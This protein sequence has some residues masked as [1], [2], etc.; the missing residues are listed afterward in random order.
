MTAERGAE[1]TPDRP[2]EEEPLVR[3]ERWMGGPDEVVPGFEELAEQVR[4]YG[5]LDP[6]ATIAG[7]SEASR[8][9][10]GALVRYVLARWSSGGSE[11]LLELG[12]SG[13]DH[14]VRL[15]EEAEAVGTD[16]ARLEAYRAVRDVVGW[17]RAGT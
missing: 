17:L 9:P 11:G 13:V 16:E 4:E 10:V 3:L 6:L 1:D 8:I 14:L 12:V 5:R 7:L 2:S 15:L